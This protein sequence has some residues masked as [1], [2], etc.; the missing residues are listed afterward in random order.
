MLLDGFI[1]LCVGPNAPRRLGLDLR[2]VV[3]EERL[4]LETLRK[5]E[6]SDVVAPDCDVV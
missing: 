2:R 3:N 5:K 1:F 4:K 6:V